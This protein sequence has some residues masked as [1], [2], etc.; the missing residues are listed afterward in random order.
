MEP[1]VSGPAD[2]GVLGDE[3]EGRVGF[4][5]VSCAPFTGRVLFSLSCAVGRL[6]DGITGEAAADVGA[7]MTGEVLVGRA[8][9]VDARFGKE[10]AGL[11]VG[12]TADVD[13][14]ATSTLFGGPE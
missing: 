6:R 9:K 10:G 5:E 1:G 11:T 13:A 12:D 2:I 14:E 8:A 4:R 3:I 7:E